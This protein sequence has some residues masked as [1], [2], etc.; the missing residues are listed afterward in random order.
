MVYREP[1][2]FFCTAE[3]L[4]ELIKKDSHFD[5][6]DGEDYKD[7]ARVVDS[8][9]SPDSLSSADRLIIIFWQRYAWPV[10]FSVIRF[11][12][13]NNI[14]RDAWLEAMEKMSRNG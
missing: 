5:L 14:P 13:D 9:Y 11:G 3:I 7:L 4:L 8:I 12:K 2:G 6:E 10:A 1:A